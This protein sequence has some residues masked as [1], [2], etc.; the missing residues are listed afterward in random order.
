MPTA[1]RTVAAHLAAAEGNGWIHHVVAIHPD[2]PG[3]H[4]SREAVRFAYIRG[5]DT[6]RQAKLRGVS[7]SHHFLHIVERN[8]TDDRPKDFLAGNSHGVSHVGE[9]CR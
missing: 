8:R 3:L 5:P 6:A 7:A 4:A 9:Y 2:G 1:L